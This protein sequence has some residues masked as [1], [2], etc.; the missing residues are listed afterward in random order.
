MGRRSRT[1]AR[2]GSC[3]SVLIA[4]ATVAPSA[5]S[6]SIESLPARS[7]KIANRRTRKITAPMLSV[8]E[9]L[10]FDALACPYAPVGRWDDCERVGVEH[11]GQ[12]VRVLLRGGLGVPAVLS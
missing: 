8:E 3:D 4:S 12:D 1:P 5:K 10:D 6:T 2:V 9:Q 7:R 11:R